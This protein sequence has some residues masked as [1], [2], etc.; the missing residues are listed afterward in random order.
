MFGGVDLGCF[1]DGPVV[2]PED[3]VMII[4]EFRTGDGDRL[5]GVV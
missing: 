4:V 2:E 5:V 3:D 1:F